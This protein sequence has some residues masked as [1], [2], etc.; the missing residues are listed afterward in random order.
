[1]RIA[2]LTLRFTQEASTG[3]LLTGTACRG[4]VRRL[5]AELRHLPGVWHFKHR[6]ITSD[7]G[8]PAMFEK[9]YQ[10]R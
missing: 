10:K 6:V 7:G 5:L 9:T 2:E 3:C 1:M 4:S 8:L